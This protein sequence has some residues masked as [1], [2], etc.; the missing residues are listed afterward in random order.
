MHHPVDGIAHTTAFDTPVVEHWLEREIDQWVNL[1]NDH[2][3]SEH[4]HHR[5]MPRSFTTQEPNTA[6]S[7]SLAILSHEQIQDWPGM[8]RNVYHNLLTT[9]VLNHFSK[10][11]FE[12]KTI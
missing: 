4:F 6:I 5:A 7:S 8:S 11:Y 10:T 2:V 12:I 3:M 1:M 9:Y